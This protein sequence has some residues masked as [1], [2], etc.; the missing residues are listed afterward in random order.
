MNGYR[1]FD[2]V[3]RCNADIRAFTRN[4][5]GRYFRGFADFD[6]TSPAA[7][8]QRKRAAAEDNRRTFGRPPFAGRGSRAS[9]SEPQRAFLRVDDFLIFER[10]RNRRAFAA[11][12]L[13]ES[14]GVRSE[15]HT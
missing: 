8:G 13:L 10:N 14:P 3:K 9:I 4:A 5:V 15:E 12:G 7:F 6:R 2:G 1:A 11:G